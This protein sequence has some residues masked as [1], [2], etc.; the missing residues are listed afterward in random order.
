M[1]NPVQKSEEMMEFTEH[2]PM[3]VNRFQ[4]PDM[5]DKGI[6][7]T[8]KFR[9]KW[10][11]RQDRFFVSWLGGLMGSNEYY[12]IHT[13]NAVALAARIQEG[14]SSTPSVRVWFVLAKDVQN[15]DHLEEAADLYEAIAQWSSNIGASRIIDL[16]KFTDVP[17]PMIQDRLGGRLLVE[18]T[19]YAK[20]KK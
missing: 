8:Q 14:L 4:M 11:E 18:E 1:A 2:V 7:M 19:M 10:P 16:D 3:T 17:K 20:P 5:N 13:K 15:K 6:W 12:F 9:A